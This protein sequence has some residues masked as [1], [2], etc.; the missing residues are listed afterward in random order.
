[1]LYS[2]HFPGI[3]RIRIS[4]VGRIDVEYIS[5]VKAAE[6]M[7][8]SKRRINY[9]CQHGEILG[10]VKEGYRWKIP[11]ENLNVKVGTG[12]KKPLPVGISDYKRAVSEYY[13]VDK[14]GLICELLEHKPLV[15]LFTRPRRFGKSLNIDML[16]TF[17]EKTKDDTSVYFEGTR[18]WCHE[19]YRKQQ[20]KYPV[21]FFSFKDVKFDTWEETF[22]NLKLLIQSEYR[23]HGYLLDSE[24]L[25]VSEK[26]FFQKML[27]GEIENAIMPAM[28]GQLI[29]FLRIHYKEK[30]VVLIDEYDT[31]IQQGYIKGY[32]DQV[33]NFMRNFLSG[34]LKDNTNLERAF[35]TGILRVAK[36]SIFSGLNNLNVNSILEERYNSYF[37]FTEAEVKKILKDYGYGDKFSL[38]KE[39]YDGYH[40]GGVEVYNPWSVLSF[41]DANGR[42]Q[43]YWQATGSNSIISEILENASEEAIENL[44]LLLEDNRVGTYIDTAVVYPEIKSNPASIYSFLLMAGYLTVDA[45]NLLLDGNAYGNVYIPNKEVK[46]AYHKEIVAKLSSIIT[47]GSAIALQQALISNDAK[48]LEM[49]MNRLLMAIVSFYDT[50]TESFYHGMLL[51]LIALLDN[52]YEIESNREAGN[53]RYD[54]QLRPFD[55]KR[56]AYII[57]IKASDS[58]L[59]LEQEAESAI[60]QI[61]DK[62]YYQKL[63]ALKIK[64]I[65]GYGMAFYK[66]KCYIVS[67]KID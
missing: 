62:Q 20:G 36:E 34:G 37:G 10:A 19:K 32:Y 64:D 3:I 38:V 46:V 12:N 18:V 59:Q 60:N 63:K 7:G 45:S 8:V 15:V 29:E 25:S 49:E 14:T 44:Y 65:V 40:F 2:S 67:K 28:L 13:Y 50:A 35:M 17:F 11:K 9:M 56:T 1:M 24:R 47:K 5:S 4:Y 61:C 52:Y 21:V 26:A 31:P 16:K 27:S 33:I 58:E 39:W 6:I 23:R 57:E 22:L 42:I 54:I 41:V 30:V 48:K 66:K 43:A 55:K 53:G 51:G